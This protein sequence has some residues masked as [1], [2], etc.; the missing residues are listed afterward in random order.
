MPFSPPRPGPVA[1]D[2]TLALAGPAAITAQGTLRVQ[3]T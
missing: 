2:G 1:A 3:S